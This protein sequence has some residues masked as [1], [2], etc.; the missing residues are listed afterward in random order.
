MMQEEVGNR[1]AALPNTKEYNAL[2]VILQH[3]YKVEKLIKVNKKMFYPVPKIDSVVIKMTPQKVADP[4]FNEF[5]KKCFKQKRKT[6]VNN[7]SN[8]LNVNKN[9]TQEA[10]KKLGIDENIRAEA[11]NLH[12]FLDI[13]EELKLK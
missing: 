13:Q 1:I 6:L 5:V 7:L 2:S 9:S 12:N 8:Q 4:V 3:Q 10:L 11:L